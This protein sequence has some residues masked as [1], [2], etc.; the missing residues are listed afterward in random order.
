M[1]GVVEFL[2]RKVLQWSVLL[3]EGVWVGFSIVNP[4]IDVKFSISV[5]KQTKT[6]PSWKYVTEQIIGL[7]QINQ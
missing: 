5:A 4:K 1:M 6:N 3:S 2:G 7:L